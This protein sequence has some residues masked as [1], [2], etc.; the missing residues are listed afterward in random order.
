MILQLDGEIRVLVGRLCDKLLAE[1]GRG[2]PI[3][4]TMAYSCLASDIISGYCL[5]LGRL[6]SR[7]CGLPTISGFSHFFSCASDRVR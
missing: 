2:K 6:A 5:T 7:S 3:D 4:V 1:Q